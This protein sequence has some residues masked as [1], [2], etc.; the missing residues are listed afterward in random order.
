MLDASASC[1]YVAKDC[2]GIVVPYRISRTYLDR[3]SLSW[4]DKEAKKV[5]REIETLT[6]LWAGDIW[7]PP[8]FQEEF[9][10]FALMKT[11]TSLTPAQS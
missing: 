6:G 2:G 3:V 7:S 4:S 8:Y 5:M 11:L 9:E 1:S 10:I